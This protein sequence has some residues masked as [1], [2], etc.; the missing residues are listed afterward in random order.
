MDA[1]SL[2]EKADI[3]P[4]A[5]QALTASILQLKAEHEQLRIRVAQDQKQIEKHQER[6]AQDQ[7]R[8]DRDQLK[9]QSLSFELAHLKRIR[10]G[11]HNE[12]LSAEQ[13]DFFTESLD[14]D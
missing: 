12:S 6:I 14:E 7:L 8:I 4:A 13:L 1:L 3:H 2:L 11:Q 10:F 9:I 5:K